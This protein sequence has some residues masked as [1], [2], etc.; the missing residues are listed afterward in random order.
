MIFVA[1]QLLEKVHEHQELLFTLFVD[2]RKAYDSVHRDAL[3]K[4][5]ERSGVPPCIC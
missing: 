5:L 3:W 1:R 4:V 2:S